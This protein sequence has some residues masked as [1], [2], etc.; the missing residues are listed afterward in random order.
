MIPNDHAI[1][2]YKFGE[3]Q[4][5]QNILDG[6]LSFSCAGAYILQA[7]H[8]G[9]NV[10]GDILEGVFAR[11][12]RDSSRISEL[13]N[14]FGGDLEVIPD[15][16]Y[17]YLRRRS[18]KLKP[19]FCIFAYTAEDALHDGKAVKSGRQRVR[20]DFDPRM[21][22]GF[23]ISSVKN[24][25]A[26]SHRFTIALLQPKP[27]VD[28]IKNSLSYEAQPYEMHHVKYIPMNE[29]EFFIEP[30]DT[31]DELFYKSADYKYQHEARICLTGEKFNNVFERYPLYIEKFGK[32]DYGECHTEVYCE[33]TATFKQV[34]DDWEGSV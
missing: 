31:Y 11:L 10:Q 13:E 34:D 21:F 28:K 16:D 20:F 4:W 26:D 15:G 23:A 2:F 22:E 32:E 30:T 5:I 24:V 8:T 27:F 9:N 33:F 19:I 29:G 18:A 3:N 6:E 7:K 12:H 14:K 25:I 17:S 1:M